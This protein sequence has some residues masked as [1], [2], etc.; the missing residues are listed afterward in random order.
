MVLLLTVLT[1]VAAAMLLLVLGWALLRIRQAL[2]SIAKSLDKIAMGVRAI[3][4]ETAPLPNHLDRVNNSL[5][6]LVPGL[7]AVHQHLAGADE[8][9]AKMAKVLSG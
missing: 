9:L 7:Q 5:A 8:K 2:E 3:D 1:W 6:P 4:T